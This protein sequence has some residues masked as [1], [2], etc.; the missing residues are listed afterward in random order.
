MICTILEIS[1][2][3]YYKYKKRTKPDKE[4]Q[5]ET[6]CSLILE[7]NA[8]YD[9]ILG[10]RRMTMFINRLNQTSYSSGYIYRLMKDLSVVARIRRK[11]VNRKKSK[12]D[13]VKDNILQE[14]LVLIDLMRNGL[15]M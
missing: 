2:S 13:Y 9:G 15:L 4:K 8:M 3:S 12:P 7:Y 14:T 1:R 5:D 11:K 6:L 10:Y